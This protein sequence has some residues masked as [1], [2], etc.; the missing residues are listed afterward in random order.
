MSYL[1]DFL[2]K[3]TDLPIDVNRHLKLIR[4]LDQMSNDKLK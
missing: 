1:E 3:S 2:E 4:E